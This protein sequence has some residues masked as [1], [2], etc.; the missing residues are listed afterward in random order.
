MI[1]LVVL[2]FS[3]SFISVCRFLSLCV[4]VVHSVSIYLFLFFTPLVPSFFHIP[5]PSLFH[6]NCTISSFFRS[7]I[8]L[9]PSVVLSICVFFYIFL[10][11]IR[12]C[13]LWFLLL[14]IWLLLLY[15]VHSFCLSVVILSVCHTFSVCCTF[16]CPSFCFQSVIHS[17]VCRSLLTVCIC[18]SFC[19]SQSI[20]FCISI[21]L[22]LWLLYFLIPLPSLFLSVVHYFYLLFFFCLSVVLFCLLFCSFCHSFYLSLFFNLSLILVSVILFY[23]SVSDVLS[24]LSVFISVIR[25]ASFFCLLFSSLCLSLFS[26]HL[27]LFS[28][29]CYFFLSV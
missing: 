29:C 5:L 6:T 12:F 23:S 26:F 22:Y 11:V 8:L 7:V 20:F 25:F 28:V 3:C 27:S 18:C 4:S 2:S 15:D 21:F 14:L 13:L 10:I 16:F 1:S 9:Y 24:F 17:F 19:L